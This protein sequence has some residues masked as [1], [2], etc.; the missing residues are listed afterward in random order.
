MDAYW[1]RSD[2]TYCDSA[3]AESFLDFVARAQNFLD[4]LEGHPA[5]D[6]AVFSHGQFL[7]AVAWLL[8]RS[9]LILDNQAMA[10]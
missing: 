3:G 1:L 4:R 7:N 5:S 8:E 2:P 10:D 9:P 6:I